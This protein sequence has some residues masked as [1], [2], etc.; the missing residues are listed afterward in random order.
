MRP[1]PRPGYW[2]SDTLCLAQAVAFVGFATKA[3]DPRVTLRQALADELLPAE[4]CIDG[5]ERL[6]VVVKYWSGP[7]ADEAF[8]R[9]YPYVPVL[10]IERFGPG[11]RRQRQAERR[12]RG[13]I[14]FKKA[15]L[16]RA[17]HGDVDVWLAAADSA[18]TSQPAPASPA[19][20]T[21]KVAK[22]P[23]EDHRKRPRAPHMIRLEEWIALGKGRGTVISTLWTDYRT[24]LRGMYPDV[25]ATVQ[26]RSRCAQF[27]KRIKAIRA[28][29]ADC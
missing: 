19:V 18:P 25:F 16:G 28:G 23:K 6:P 17:F 13:A 10:V 9:P 2:P 24:W 1:I 5:G 29:R 8:N 3:P 11:R 27:E 15:D 22:A 7:T 20:R 26:N 21:Q 14:V 4:L 12:E